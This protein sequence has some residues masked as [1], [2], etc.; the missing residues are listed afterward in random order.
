MAYGVTA[1]TSFNSS[2]FPAGFVFGA[3]S[4]A[5]QY[6]GAFRE[7][8][9][10]PSIWDTFTHD[11]PGLQIYLML[12]NC[13]NESNQSN[14]RRTQL[15]PPSPSRLLPLSSPASA[16]PAVPH[17]DEEAWAAGKGWRRREGEGPTVQCSKL[18]LSRALD[19]EICRRS[20]AP[21]RSPRFGCLLVVHCIVN[22]LPLVVL[23]KDFCPPTSI[24]FS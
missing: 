15:P 6:E 1:S 24:L 22:C 19:S 10:G 16:L 13:M 5:Y 21:K 2:S 14:E 4:A 12:E 23:G 11:H 20:I 17:R 18:F 9:K 3:A 7:G 8:G